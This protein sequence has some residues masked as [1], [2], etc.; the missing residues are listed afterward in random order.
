MVYLVVIS[1]VPAVTPV[2]DKAGLLTLIAACVSD[3]LVQAGI[4][5]LSC[6]FGFLLF[7]QALDMKFTVLLRRRFVSL[8]LPLLIWNI[9][10]LIILYLAQSRGLPAVGP[11]PGREV[12][13]FDLMV[14]LNGVLSITSHPLNQPMVFLRDLFVMCLLAPLAGKLIRNVPYIGLAVIL[15]VFVPGLDGLLIYND[16]VPVTFYLGGMAATMGWNLRNLD[17]HAVQLAG[18]MIFVSFVFVYLDV[19]QPGWLAMLA[20]LAVWPASSLIVNKPVGRWLAR[21]TRASFFLFL[22]HGMVITML[23]MVFPYLYS[24]RFEFYVW[25]TVPIVAAIFSQ[26]VFLFLDRFVPRFLVLLLGGC[27]PDHSTTAQAGA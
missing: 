7:G 4:P 2:A 9:P 8:V 6:I 3:G 19:A 18:I 17:R 12:Y 16:T 24:G 21:L 27:K 20:P 15:V 5:V 22:F 11:S 10:L 14:W 26:F 25:L 23:K 1:S 13:P